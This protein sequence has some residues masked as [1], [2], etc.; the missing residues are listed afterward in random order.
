M[1]SGPAHRRRLLR[2]PFAWLAGT[3]LARSGLAQSTP[4]DRKI[5]LVIGNSRYKIGELKIPRTMP[6][7]WAIP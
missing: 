5:A 2:G 7:R 1:A 3:A 4:S 6:A